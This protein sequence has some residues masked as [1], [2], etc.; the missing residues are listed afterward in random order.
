MA[1][2]LESLDWAERW[3]AD[4]FR[5]VDTPGGFA[6]YDCDMTRAGLL[7]ERLRARGVKATFNHVLVRAAALALSRLPELHQLV[8]GTRRLAPERVD[9]GLSVAGTTSFAPVMVLEDAGRK[10]LPELASEILRRIPEVQA[11]EKQDLEVMRRWGWL[12][13]WGRLRRWLLRWLMSRLWFRRQLAGTFQVSCNAMADVTVPFLFN[14]AACLGTGRVRDA[15]VPI[16]GQPQVRKVT[17]LAC[18]IDHKVW[19]GVRAARFAAEIR[20]ILEQGELE[21]EL[22]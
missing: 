1:D 8:A 13:P 7:V 9:I 3:L 22:G 17:T 4:G 16:D 20:Q 19:D 21:A 12:I 15:V 10:A 2:R 18:C 11:K 14:T 5:V 6:L